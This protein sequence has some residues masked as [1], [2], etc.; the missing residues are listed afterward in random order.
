MSMVTAQQH[1]SAASH[2]LAEART[3][4][5]PSQRY[6]GAHLAAIRAAAAVVESRQPFPKPKRPEPIRPVWELLAERA[7][8]MAEW[9][10]QYA[11]SAVKRAQIEMG[12]TMAVTQREADVLVASTDAFIEACWDTA[13]RVVA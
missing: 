11:K 1:L 7:P 4:R 12:D 3:E 5:Y 2:A 6:V 10:A 13:Y 8:E 9:A